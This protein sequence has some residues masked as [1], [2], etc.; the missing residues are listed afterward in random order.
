[1]SI[2]EVLAPDIG[3]SLKYSNLSTEEWKAI[4]SLADDRS[5]VIK[6]ADEGSAVVVWEL[7]DYIKE[8]K[9]QLEDK[10]VSEG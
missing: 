1:M 9:K 6:K 10:C 5:I 4:K 2:Q 8:A 7:S 3:T